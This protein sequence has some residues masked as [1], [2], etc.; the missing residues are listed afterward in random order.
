[1]PSSAQATVAVADG[2]TRVSLPELI[3]LR[4][5]V[6]R[7][8]RLHAVAARASHG[9]HASRL[10]GRGMDY[11]ESR[12]YQ[13]GDDVRQIDWRLT[14]RSGRVHTKL[15]Q[16]ERERSLLLLVDC[17][18]SMYFGTRERF[19]SVQ[20][21]RAAALAAWHAARAGERVGV[22]AIGGTRGVQRPRAGERGAL[23]VVG[24][25]AAWDAASQARESTPSGETLGDALHRAQRLA[26]GSSRVLLVS[27]G[28]SCDAQARNRLL[29][30]RRH[31]EVSM[32]TV[33]D[34]LELAPPPPGRYP[35][36]HD[37]ERAVVDL[38]GSVQRRAFR[39]MLGEGPARLQALCSATGLRHRAIDTR[40]DPLPAVTFLL[41]RPGRGT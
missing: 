33:A 9:G 40:A 23:A 8:P 6:S 31:A 39:Q 24:A 3:A 36:E 25:L 4:L 10:R 1:M 19:K 30:L 37:G 26:R 22:L 7:S 16:E 18:A 32:L 13:P 2:I 35:F 34:V 41:G 17:N 29:Q 27:D 21:A 14:A 28:W 11:V 12:A 20:A 5:Q 38:H 15:F